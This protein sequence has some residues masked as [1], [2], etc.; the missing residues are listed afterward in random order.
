MSWARANRGLV[1]LALA[2]LAWRVLAAVALGQGLYLW[3]LRIGW[4]MHLLPAGELRANPVASLWYLQ[5]QPPVYNA[6]TAV[7]LQLPSATWAP[8]VWT[9]SVAAGLVATTFGYQALVEL[10]V[11]RWLAFTGV[12]VGFAL[13]PGVL[14]GSNYYL[15][16]SWAAAMLSASLLC[17]VRWLERRRLGWGLGF[18]GL[19][20]LTV[21]TDSL[22][23][24]PWMLGVLGLLVLVARLR[25]RA[26][27]AA[28]A[29]PVAL[30]GLLALKDL[31]Q[32]AQ[33]TTSSWS[34]IN[35]SRRVFA[36]ADP[37]VVDAMVRSGELTGIAYTPGFRPLGPR[38]GDGRS[39]EGSIERGYNAKLAV[40]R[41][42]HPV[43]DLP[44]KAN[45]QPNYN[46]EAYA[47]ASAKLLADS[48]AFI[49]AHP[50]SYLKGSGSAMAIW[51][52]PTSDN[53]LYAG[54]A[55]FSK[56][57]VLAG[58]NA[59]QA[60]GGMH[61]PAFDAYAN[62][63]NT[64]VGLAFERGREGSWIDLSLR[65]ITPRPAQVSWSAVLVTSL[66]LVPLGL[67]GLWRRRDRTYATVALYVWGSTAMVFAISTLV[68][69]GEN[70]R[71]RASL[72]LL[73]LAG[74]L[75][76]VQAGLDAW[77]RRRGSAKGAPL[78]GAPVDGA[79]PR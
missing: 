5:S 28:A 78:G 77:R 16:S 41:T 22:F 14:L 64:V 33:P 70:D 54:T 58:Y 71:F 59:W 30:V 69:V 79:R 13:N 36:T 51:A 35:L 19:A 26:L 17:L 62:A 60:R 37:A 75:L 10:R 76:V 50:A 53:F 6:A 72:G 65:A 40:P 25:G 43:L 4:E 42:G 23:Q 61:T 73:P 34:G 66:C 27:W 47:Q 46:S 7:L 63:Y 24:W 11:D 9:A 32:F 15:Y 52:L 1:A 74:A 29:V 2:Y 45:G 39:Y 55:T 8:L 21:Y 12:L 67:L 18:C 48:L 68:E 38:S 31:A 56:A 57:K 49:A 44:A 3:P 20:A